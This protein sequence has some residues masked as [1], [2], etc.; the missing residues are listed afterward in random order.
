MAKFF[1]K[2]GYSSE[3]VEIRPGVYS[4]E[5]VEMPYKGDVLKRSSRWQTSENVNDNLVMP[6]R[7]SILADA[8]AYQNFSR[9]KYVVWMGVKWKVTEIEPQRP[10]L[11]LTIGGEYN[12]GE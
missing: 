11:I 3:M 12:D 4:D 8:Y 2:V 6:Q 10:R 1:G 9:I 7:I 5:I